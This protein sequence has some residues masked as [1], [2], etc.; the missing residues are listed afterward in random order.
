MARDSLPMVSLDRVQ[1]VRVVDNLPPELVAKAKELATRI[2]T[3]D[4]NAILQFGMQ[5]QREATTITQPY[6]EKVATKD[7][8]AIGQQLSSL[9]ND[10]ESLN[11]RALVSMSRAAQI[12][13]VGRFFDKAKQFIDR[14]ES[15]QKKID[16][17]THE[18]EMAARQLG[19]DIEMLDKLYQMNDNYRQALYIFIAA[20]E[21]KLD[22]LNAE[23]SVA[24]QK[25]QTSNHF[26]D[27]EDAKKMQDQID[28]LE[29]KLHDLKLTAFV[30][31]QTG[32]QIDLVRQNNQSLAE[33]IQ[34]SILATIPLWK[35]QAVIAIALYNQQR[36]A[37]L[38]R[39]V[40]DTTNELLKTNAQMLRQGNAEVAREVQRGIVDIETLV[41]THQNLIGTLQDSLRI[42]EEGRARRASAEQKMH[43]LQREL[44]AE[45]LKVQTGRGLPPSPNQDF[46]K[47]N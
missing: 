37:K 14:Y 9:L 44:Q 18:L 28:R 23:Y 47:L 1:S 40:T 19:R 13:V 27:A 41:E 26:E 22:D 33:K 35:Q 17:I 21:L 29:R 30:S 36:H 10:T 42:Q 24:L 6:L 15:I 31:L 3:R 32:P 2:D 46:L 16:G 34:T 8:G 7:S 11:P 5:A 39:R 38:Q 20:G 45:L 4:T 12:P 43:E 25:A